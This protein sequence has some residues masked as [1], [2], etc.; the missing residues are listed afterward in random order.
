MQVRVFS[1]H[2]RSAC[3]NSGANQV[4]CSSKG[5]ECFL[6]TSCLSCMSVCALK[7]MSALFPVSRGWGA[8]SRASWH[9]A[10][11]SHACLVLFLEL[12]RAEGQAAGAGQH[13]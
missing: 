12:G 1:C 11:G 5:L 7:D 9:R 3:N 6:E 2:D 4:R 10:Y 8:H 13:S